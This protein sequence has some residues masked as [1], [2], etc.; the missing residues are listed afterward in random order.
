MATASAQTVTARWD[1]LMRLQT[2][3]A[4][5]LELSF[6]FNSRTWLEAETVLDVGTGNAYYLR[7]LARYFPAKRYVGIDTDPNH[8]EVAKRE[9]PTEAGRDVPSLQLLVQD[10]HDVRGAYDVAV[11][12]LLVQH[13]PSVADF[14]TSMRRAIRPGGLLIVIESSDDQRKFV[15]PVGS[16]VRFFEAF[17]AKRRADGCNR[18]AGRLLAE[19]ASQFGFEAEAGALLVVPSTIPG[20]KDLFL[21]THLTVLDVV[22]G[23]FQVDFD[24]GRL[25]ADLKRWWADPTSYT[26]LGVHIASYR[27][28]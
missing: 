11:A 16:M 2:D 3:L 27:H 7:Q 9:G 10:A 14:L 19:Q 20:H 1:R 21:E 8:I 18:D 25:A 23:A 5:P 6:F 4:Q 12:R 13:L 15:P 17:R 26:Q 22:Q 28:I 24:Y